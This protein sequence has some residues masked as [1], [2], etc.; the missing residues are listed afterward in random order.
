MLFFTLKCL[1]KNTACIP[2]AK[3]YRTIQRHGIER[4]PCNIIPFIY[5]RNH[6]ISTFFLNQTPWQLPTTSCTCRRGKTQAA[7]PET[8]RRHFDNEE[9]K[10]SYIGSCLILVRVER[11]SSSSWKLKST[12]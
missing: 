10:D 3:L 12:A 9:R 1:F 6:K 8:P 2:K 11:R 5:Y 7:T 4:F